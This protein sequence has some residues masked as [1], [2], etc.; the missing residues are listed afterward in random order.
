MP[1]G[2]PAAA[3]IADP[4]LVAALSTPD[5]LRWLTIGDSV[6][7]GARWTGAA[8]D[9]V[10][11][12]E[13]RVRYELE[14]YPD[15]FVRAAVS[16]ARTTDTLRTLP[17]ALAVEPDVVLVGLGLND[18]K[19]GPGGLA[20]FERR[21]DELAA[22]VITAGALPVLQ[23]PNAVGPGADPVLAANLDGYAAVIRTVALRREVPLVDHLTYWTGA[24]SGGAPA[25]WMADPTHPNGRGHRM[26]AARLLSVCGL[27]AADSRLCALL[28]ADAVDIPEAVQ[29]QGEA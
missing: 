21:F 20:E 15:T 10:Q 27:F 12:L 29:R 4:R 23:T 18:A 8:R 16:G 5:P 19:S 2:G 26:L 14:R 13:E 6:A 17:A 24:G 11:L 1:T 9:Y 25:E 7:Q 3:S 28:D 22:T